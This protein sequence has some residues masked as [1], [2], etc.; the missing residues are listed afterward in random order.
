MLEDSLD[1]MKLKKQLQTLLEDKLDGELLDKLPSGYSIIGDIAVF[2]HINQELNDYKQDI[3]EIVIYA[4]PQVNVV[5][6]QFSTNSVYRKPQIIHLAG[7]K[8]TITKHREYDTIFNIDV[9]EL[10]FSPGN[11]GERM[12]LINSVQDNEVLVDMFA[13]IG[14]LSLPV[15]VNNPT[16]KCYGIEINDVAFKYL[17]ENLKENQVEDRYFPLHGDNRSKSP[18]DIATR[19]LMGYF[20]IDTRQFLRAVE[21]IKEKGWIHYH[22]LV[23]RDNIKKSKKK[24]QELL[25][26]ANSEI[27]L[28]DT[29]I[30]KKYSPRLSHFCFDLHVKK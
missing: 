20:E 14:N 24:I 8:R 16:V 4:D 25:K 5:V 23:E 1:L 21:A 3:G 6:E 30:V 28:N 10:T 26:T 18:T 17:V 27:K 7:E 2:R 11:K 29:R 13:C 9:S 22:K 12:F 19:V 15:I